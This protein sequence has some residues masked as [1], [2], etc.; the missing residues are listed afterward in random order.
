MQNFWNPFTKIAGGKALFWGLA[1]LTVSVVCA[2]FCGWHAH[3]LLHFGPTPRDAWWIFALEY[4]TIWLV[5]AAL[6]YGLGAALSRSRIR[7]VDVFG[8]TAFA[9]LPLAAMNLVLSPFNKKAW[10]IIGTTDTATGIMEPTA[11]FTSPQFI[12]S[13]IATIISVVLML[14]WMFN[15]VKVSCNLKGGRLWTVYLVGVMG[16]DIV[17]RLLIGLLY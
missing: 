7:P 8:T 15:A 2:N 1:G 17:C 9:L 12:V 5:P 3:G 11:V 10:G 14:I 16:G 4:L 6:F 13:A